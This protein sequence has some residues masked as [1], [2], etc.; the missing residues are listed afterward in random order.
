MKEYK[1]LEEVMKNHNKGKAKF[2]I[3]E[4]L[5]EI[6]KDMSLLVSLETSLKNSGFSD[7]RFYSD[8]NESYKALSDI[9]DKMI[10]WLAFIGGER[11]E[12]L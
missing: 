5:R 1:S 4:I 6:R 2:Y 10:G 8:I 11:D 12:V 3:I 7:I 9:E